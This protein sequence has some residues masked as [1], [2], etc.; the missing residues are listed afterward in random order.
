MD[1]K[2]NPLDIKE[3][4]EK[5]IKVWRINPNNFLGKDLRHLIIACLDNK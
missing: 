3:V 2:L 5:W 4:V 1:I